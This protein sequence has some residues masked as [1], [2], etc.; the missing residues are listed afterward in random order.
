MTRKFAFLFTVAAFAAIT[1]IAGGC[2]R[3]KAAVDGTTVTMV[4]G[5]EPN[6]IDPAL[7]S[8]VDAGIYISHAFEGLYKYVDDGQGRAVAVPGQ[9]ADAPQKTV[10]PDGTV[11][12]LYTLRDGLKWSDGAELTADDFVYAWRRL[13]DPATAADYSSI[14]DMVKNAGAIMDGKMDSGGLGIRAIDDKTLEITLTYDCPFFD[15]IT[16]FPAAFPVRQDV[17]EKAGDQ[18]TF[19]PSTYIGNGPYRLKEWAHNSYLLFE[20][21]PDYY[22]PVEDGPDNLRF[23]LM[24]DGNTMLAAFRSGELDFIEVVPVDEIPSLLDSGELKIADYLG[25]YFVSMNTRRPPFTDARVRKAFTLAIDRDYLIRQIVRTGQKPAGGFVPAGMTDAE[26]GSDFRRTGGDYYSLNP[27]DY[28]KNVAE[29]RRLLADAGYPNGNGFPVVE[30]IYN[31]DNVHRAVAEALQDMW[32][33]GL[34]VTVTLGN[35]DWA[36]FIDSRKTGDYSLARDGWIGDY[37]DPISFLDLF[38]SGG[39]NNNPQ[40]TN[41]EYDR[42]IAAANGTAVQTDRMRFLHEAEDLLVGADYAVAPLYFYTQTYMM[43]PALS[44]MYYTPLG[45]FF[46][47][48]VKGARIK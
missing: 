34:G 29:A 14:L 41:P 39:G 43:N 28:E 21:N 5:S 18:W 40:Y 44:G 35:Q 31:T 6:T 30:Y 26:P 2:G 38:R 22:A 7:N 20:R 15:Q 37:N 11:V 45:F 12:Y 33:T 10:N 42:L 24:D 8:A 1:V 9:A 47:A 46:F 17:L 48:G 4:F 25:T 27:A 13:V 23:A 16:A 19:S 3:Q 32:R 36:V